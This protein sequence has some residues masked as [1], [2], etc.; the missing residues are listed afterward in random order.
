MGDVEQFEYDVAVVGLAGRFPG[1]RNV[2]EFWE[3]LRE[4]SVDRKSVV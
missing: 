3:R 1:A 4:G 2:T